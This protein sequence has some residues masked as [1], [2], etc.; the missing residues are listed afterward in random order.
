MCFIVYSAQ[1]CRDSILNFNFNTVSKNKKRGS[2]LITGILFTFLQY[3]ALSFSL[4]LSSNVHCLISACVQ[5]LISSYLTH[6]TQEC[7]LLLN[8]RLNCIFL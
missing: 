1:L 3:S 5:F 2:A 4:A 8:N 6:Q 7:L